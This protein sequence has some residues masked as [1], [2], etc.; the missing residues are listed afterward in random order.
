[1]EYKYYVSQ[2]MNVYAAVCFVV[3]PTACLQMYD[4]ASMLRML[5]IGSVL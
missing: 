5:C 1:M 3:Q 2:H 4:I